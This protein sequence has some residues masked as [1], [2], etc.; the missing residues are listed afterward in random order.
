MKEVGIGLMQKIKDENTFI[1]QLN[2]DG[3]PFAWGALKFLLEASGAKDIK[4]S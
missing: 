4:E 1:V 2:V 3:F